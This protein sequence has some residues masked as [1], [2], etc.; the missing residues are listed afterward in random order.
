MGQQV[1][2]Y[3]DKEDSKL[4]LGLAEDIGFLALPEIVIHDPEETNIETSSPTK[5]VI[6]EGQDYFYLLPKTFSVV[7]AFYEELTS[8]P[9]VWKL[10][11]H[12]SPVV[13]LK[14]C[15]Q[16]DHQI[17][18]GRIYLNTELNDVR[19]SIV[20]ERY[21]SLANCI[22]K[23]EKTDRFGFYV[24]PHTANSVREGDIVLKHFRH[25]LKVV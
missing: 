21:S 9:L 2:F 12:K 24:G 5:F 15:P 3:I 22:R 4:L 23:W 10:M 13:Q 20:K 25:E 16:L 8:T 19:Y 14:L 11:D 18:N 7:E 1:G 17:Y 6:P